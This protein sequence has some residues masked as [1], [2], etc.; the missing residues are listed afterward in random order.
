MAHEFAIRNKKNDKWSFVFGYT[1]G[2]MYDAF[3][4]QMH[5]NGM[6]GDGDL[7]S[8]TKHE[9]MF[10]LDHAIAEFD[11]MNYPDPCRMDDIR[12]FRKDML[13]DDEYD[14]YEICYS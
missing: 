5:N 8:K 9:V 12:K 3:G 14:T 7:I 2:I 10:A 13:S 1:N 11:K 4:E 6:S